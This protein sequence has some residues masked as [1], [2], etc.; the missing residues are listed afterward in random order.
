MSFH[1]TLPGLAPRVPSYRRHKPTGQAVVTL[2][3]RDFYVG[4]WSTRASRAEYDRLIGEWLAAG[5]CL[6]GLQSGFTVAEIVLRYWQFAT[7]YYQ[8]N[9]EPSGWLVHIRL[10]L[11]L[12]RQS[13]WFR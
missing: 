5:R 12:R 2:N 11:R 7:G 4:K 13:S 3:G 1:S 9:G 8:K 6:P 10:L